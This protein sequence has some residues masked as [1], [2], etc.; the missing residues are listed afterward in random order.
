V[1]RRIV[2]ADDHQLLRA[3]LRSLLATER[4]LEVIGEASDGREAV[5]LVAVHGPDLVIMDIGMPNLNGIE[6]TRQVRASSPRTK[7]IALSMHASAPFVSRMLEAGAAGYLLKESAYEELLQAVR[8]VLAGQTY[9]SRDITGVVVDDYVR[10]IGAATQLEA[11]ALTPREREVA[12]MIAEGRSTKE[13]AG[14]LHVSV[15]TIET[16]R[17]HIMEKLKIGSVAELTKYA[18]REGLTELGG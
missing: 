12:Q 17:Q 9:L 4:D 2:L 3:G 13:I 5:D 11:A 16:H 8:A 14:E 7:V 1:S 10:R 15:K 18:I 6:A